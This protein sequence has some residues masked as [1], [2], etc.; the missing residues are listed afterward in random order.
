MYYIKIIL[1]DNNKEYYLPIEKALLIPIIA[2]EI[3]N[4][5][6]R[7]YHLNQILLAN[8]SKDE[9]ISILYQLL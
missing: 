6:S 2:R 3:K 9:L 4:K 7:Q 8:Y 5:S 1:I